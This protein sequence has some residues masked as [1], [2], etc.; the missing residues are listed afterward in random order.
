MKNEPMTIFG[1]GTQTRAFS[2][3]DDVVPMIA[4]SVTIAEAYNDVFNVGAD[5]PYK[6]LEVAQSVGEAFGVEPKIT[7]LPARHEVLHA[8]S[9]HDKSRRVFGQSAEIGL[10]D[11][12]ARMAKWARIRGA[13]VTKPFAY[14]EVG[15]NMPPSWAKQLI[16]EKN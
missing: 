5:A 13:Q 1:D 2:Y 16:T 8:Y 7:F 12:I 10:K 15:R 4:K 14:V 6:V 9:S 3:I 11:G